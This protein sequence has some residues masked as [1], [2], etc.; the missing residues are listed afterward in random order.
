MF[1]I[2]PQCS[3]QMSVL[4]SF[5]WLKDVPLYDYATFCVSFYLLVG[6]LD[7]FCLLAVVLLWTL[8]GEFFLFQHLLA[9]LL[10]LFLGVGLVGHMVI[11]C[12]TYLRNY[13]TL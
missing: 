6:L 2:R 12:L 10:A 13:Q 5:A 9:L 8:M 11:V 1:R 3:R 7:C 4:H